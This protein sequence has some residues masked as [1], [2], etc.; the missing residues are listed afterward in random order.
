MESEEDDS[1]FVYSDKSFGK[2][3]TC[4]DDASATMSTAESLNHSQFGNSNHTANWQSSEEDEAQCVVLDIDGDT[5][6]LP[7]P[8][9]SA[10]PGFDEDDLDEGEVEV[11]VHSGMETV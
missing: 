9:G 7:S 11:P 2:L 3:D 5:R 10:P 1:C 4:Q 8:A 6:L